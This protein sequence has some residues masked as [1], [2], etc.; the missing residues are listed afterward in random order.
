MDPLRWCPQ[1][2]ILNATLRDNI[3]FGK[4]FNRRK[5]NAAVKAS[6]LTE[7]FSILPSGDMTEIGEKGINLSGKGVVVAGGDVV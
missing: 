2:W 5:Y 4:P 3:L 1:A 7:D 6:E